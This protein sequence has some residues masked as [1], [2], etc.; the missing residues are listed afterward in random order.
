MNTAIQKRYSP[1]CMVSASDIRL[2]WDEGFRVRTLRKTNLLT[3]LTA[4]ISNTLCTESKYGSHKIQM[5]N[6]DVVKLDL[7]AEMFTF[8]QRFTIFFLQMQ[9]LLH[10]CPN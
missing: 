4:N 1:Q 8:G 5:N 3:L 2:G 9:N 10:K 7:L 6:D